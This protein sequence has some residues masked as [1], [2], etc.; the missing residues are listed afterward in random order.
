VNKHRGKGLI[1]EFEGPRQTL[2][3]GP[4][5][6]AIAEGRCVALEWFITT[7]FAKQNAKTPKGD[8]IS[9]KG[10]PEAN[11][12]PISTPGLCPFSRPHIVF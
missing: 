10:G 4:Q 7:S 1:L 3:N 9:D 8:S 11:A 2:R 12:S 6:I 5:N